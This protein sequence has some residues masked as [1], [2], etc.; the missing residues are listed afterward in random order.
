MKL[1]WS[2]VKPKKRGVYKTTKLRAQEQT[3]KANTFLAQ[4]F[5]EYL[6]QNPELALEIAIARYSSQEWKQEDAEPLETR[7]SRDLK[8]KSNVRCNGQETVLD[9]LLNSNFPKEWKFVGDGQ[10]IIGRKCPDF[11]NIGDKKALIEL[12]GDFWHKGQDS[13]ER[14]DHFKKYGYSCLVIWENELKDTE[15]VISKVKEHFY[16]DKQPA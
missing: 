13:Q 8:D 15:S 14:I 7:I 12:F 3:D 2:K 4:T 16:N 11:T 9:N 5:L 1:P 6:K 10:L